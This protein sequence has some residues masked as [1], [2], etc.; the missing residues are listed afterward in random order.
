MNKKEA[1]LVGAALGESRAQANLSDLGYK[2]SESA[3]DLAN[4]LKSTSDTEIKA[5]DRVDI[6]LE[7]YERLKQENLR[8][9]CEASMLLDFITRIGVPVEVFDGEATIDHVSMSYCDYYDTFKRRYRVEFD[10]GRR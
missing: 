9:S 5:R 7:E 3:R 6:S 4:A 2:I 8:L 10:V 1:F